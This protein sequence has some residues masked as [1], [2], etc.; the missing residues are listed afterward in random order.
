MKLV[1][2]QHISKAL[3]NRGEKIPHL[4]IYQFCNLTDAKTIVA[5]NPLYAAYMPCRVAMVQDK[6]GKT[7]LMMLNLD[8]LVDN[9]LVS[10]KIVKTVINVNQKMLEIMTAGVTG[11]F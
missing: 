2:E 10:K 3:A 1:G 8:I 11:E 4:A 6:K 9:T 7:W 5:D